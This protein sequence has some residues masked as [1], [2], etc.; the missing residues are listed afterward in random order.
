LGLFVISGLWGSVGQVSAGDTGV[1]TSFGAVQKGDLK[2]EGLYFVTPWIQKVHIMDTKPYKLTIEKESAFTSDRQD[3]TFDLALIVQVDPSTADK[4]YD[5]Y[6]DS[7][8]DTLITPKVLE[9]AKTITAKFTAKE[10]ITRRGEVQSEMLA[11]I[12]RETLGK[13]VIIPA[14]ALSITNF[15]YNSD[16]QASIEAT[17]VSQQNAVKAQNDL[18]VARI[19]AQEAVVKAQGEAAAQGALARS[20]SQKSLGYKFLD[21][22]DGRLPAV[23]GS[24]GNL[25]DVSNLIGKQD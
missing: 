16:Y 12:Q 7:I 17:A 10:Q 5:Q 11:Y 22:W 4:T 18:I 24:S 14:G 13:G 21:K 6:R 19:T 3:V 20:I 9:A 1:V 2:S 25:L 8:V 15:E 23:M